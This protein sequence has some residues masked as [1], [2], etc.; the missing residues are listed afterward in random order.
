MIKRE[1]TMT[2][3]KIAFD[4]TNTPIDQEPS[5]CLI[6]GIFED[7]DFTLSVKT[8]NAALGNQIQK[9][10]DAGDFI[11]KTGNTL[12]VDTCSQVSAKRVL[13]LGCGARIQFKEKNYL[14]VLDMAFAA[15]QN[16]RYK[17]A[18]FYV[19]ELPVML[20]NIDWQTRHLVIQAHQNFYRFD[21]Y[22]SEKSDCPFLT[23]IKIHAPTAQDMANCEIAVNQAQA[24]ASGMKAT[25]DLANTPCNICTPSFVAEQSQKLAQAYTS[26]KAKI[27]T[28]KQLEKMGFG[29]FCSV[30]KGSVEDAKLVILE[31]Q[32]ATD[33]SAAPYALVGKG[34]TFDTGGLSL[35]PA[36]NML[37]MKYDMTGAAAVFG[38]MKAIA[39]LKL[40]INVVAALACA[41]NMPDGMATKP[42]SVV[43]SLSGLTVEITNT[44]AE[45][46]LV[47]CDTLTYVEKNYHPKTMI[48]VATLTGA[49]MV[50]LGKDISGFFSNDENLSE[51][52]KIAAKQ[53]YD[54][55]WQM[56]IDETYGEFLKSTVADMMNASLA[57]IAGAGVAAYYLSRFV[58]H[59]PWVH[60][61]IAG[62][63][64]LSADKKAATGRPVPLLTQYLINQAN[65]NREA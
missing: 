13:L 39:E 47:L 56:P 63:A 8:L 52:I 27:F 1:N 16:T 30:S 38:T 12:L 22:K 17:N 25:Q 49:I 43:T 24:I 58:K 55:T 34:I 4:I 21:E 65:K 35:K 28:E 62:V 48:D 54:P 14:K 36:V 19:T 37:E 60:L 6:V 45:G 3:A 10:M 42:E 32:G 23:N 7:T 20:R 51:D 50:A 44:D 33:K 53:S 9:C 61:D 5:D 41:E 26:M 59:T 11:P 40:P 57:R 15:L 29:A 64:N 46:R 2:F 18:T 31:Y